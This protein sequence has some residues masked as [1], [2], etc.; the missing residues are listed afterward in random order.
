MAV[1]VLR[2]AQSSE[3]VD[4]AA[5]RLLDVLVE[6]QQTQDAVHLCLTGGRIANRI[7]AAVADLVPDSALDAKKLHLWWSD[8]RFLPTSDPERNSLQSLALLGGKLHLVPSQI[9]SMPASDGNADPGESAFAYAHEVEDTIFDLAILGMGPDGHVASL[10]P[11]HPSSKPTSALAIGVTEAPK[12][13][14]E[15]ISLTLAALNRSREVWLWVV[16]SEKSLAVA[17]ALSGEQNLPAA[18]V[19]GV[20]RT[21]WFLDQEAAQH[22]PTYACEL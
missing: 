10:F 1:E 22:V 17:R 12:P 2:F 3:L 11:D 13:P 15:R 8:E 6:R 7:Y 21:L 14:P 16:G 5:A 9:H 19:S 18:R 4:Y 20:D